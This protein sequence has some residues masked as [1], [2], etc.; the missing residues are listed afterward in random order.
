MLFVY[1]NINIYIYVSW[2]D[3]IAKFFLLFWL[4]HHFS[5]FACKLKLMCFY[6]SKERIS[7]KIKI[8][9]EQPQKKKRNKSGNPANKHPKKNKSGTTA[10][11]KVVLHSI[12]RRYRN[13]KINFTKSTK[14][15]V[16]KTKKF[17][18]F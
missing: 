1:I 6:P 3:S 14:S 8:T 4:W 2:F 7:A 15:L 18:E 12:N 16:K 5:Y 11:F 17:K 9:A 13:H 10:K